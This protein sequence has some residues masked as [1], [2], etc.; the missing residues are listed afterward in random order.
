MAQQFNTT[1]DGRERFRLVTNLPVH[2]GTSV[3]IEAWG[4][5]GSTQAAS[6]SVPGGLPAPS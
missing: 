5:Q 2:P 1:A 6:T 3:E 4:G